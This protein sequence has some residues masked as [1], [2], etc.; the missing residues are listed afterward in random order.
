MLSVSRDH[1]RRFRLEAHQACMLF[2]SLPLTRC[3]FFFFDWIAGSSQAITLRDKVRASAEFRR[4]VTPGVAYSF[5]L[6]MVPTCASSCLFQHLF[7]RQ[8][9]R[10]NN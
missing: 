7:N 3:C 9:L 6:V 4:K 2:I 1:N 8:W 5:I 10:I